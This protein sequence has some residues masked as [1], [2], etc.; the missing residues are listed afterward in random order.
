MIHKNCFPPFATAALKARPSGSTGFHLFALQMV[1][2]NPTPI[3]SAPKVNELFTP[4]SIDTLSVGFR[5]RI[6]LVNFHFPNLT[7]AL[8]VILFF[9]LVYFNH[10]QLFPFLDGFIR[11]CTA[12][13][14]ECRLLLGGG[15]GWGFIPSHQT[16][17]KNQTACKQHPEERRRQRASPGAWP[18]VRPL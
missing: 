16:T 9:F 3:R 10:L 15:G 14:I 17:A 12:R 13:S 5:R 4:E 1:L 8:S 18:T 6:M 2:I 7:L 11:T